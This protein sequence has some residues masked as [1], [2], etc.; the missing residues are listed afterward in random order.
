[1]SSYGKG[2]GF[3]HRDVNPRL[4]FRLQPIQASLLL[5]SDSRFAYPP[6]NRLSKTC[7]RQPELT[8]TRAYM[9]FHR[10]M[11]S[12]SFRVI[13]SRSTLSRIGTTTMRP[14]AFVRMVTVFEP[15]G[16]PSRTVNTG[17]AEASKWPVALGLA[18]TGYAKVHFMTIRR[19]VSAGPCD[20]NT[21]PRQIGSW[22]ESSC[23]VCKSMALGS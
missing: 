16:P 4:R 19:V 12:P 23:T 20:E 5:V 8:T 10:T 9:R 7:I 15:H 2:N 21:R 6:V 17:S 22:T 14:R 1:M 3:A 13:W 11:L 18:R